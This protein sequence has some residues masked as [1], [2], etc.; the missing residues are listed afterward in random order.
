MEGPEGRRQQQ[1]GAENA[2]DLASRFLTQ[3]IEVVVADLV[4]AWTLPIYRRRLP[5]LLVVRLQIDIGE[6]QRRATF[7]P[8]HLT[9]REFADLHHQEATS[10]LVVDHV[11]DV[12]TMTLEEQT[13]AV[14]DLWSDLSPSP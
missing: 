11:L 12:S 14:L 10:T 13:T 3:D 8:V 9:A 7:R 5:H 6:A 1:L 4:D 2:S